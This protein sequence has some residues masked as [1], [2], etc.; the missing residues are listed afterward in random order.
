MSLAFKASLLTRFQG[1][2]DRA[3]ALT[4]KASVMSTAL[5]VLRYTNGGFQM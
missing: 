2:W 5:V 1:K 3:M 4:F